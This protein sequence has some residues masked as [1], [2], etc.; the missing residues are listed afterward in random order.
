M[1]TTT[2]LA[3][4]LVGLLLD[5]DPVQ[6]TL[7]G[8][9]GRDDRLPVIGAAAEWELRRRCDDIRMR[10]MGIDTAHAGLE[11]RLTV[12]VVVQHAQAMVDH[13]DARAAEYT[14]IG[15][16]FAPVAGLLFHLGQIRIAD[17]EQGRDY[18]RRLRAIPEFTASAADRHRAGVAAG[19]LPVRRL[20]DDA[21]AHLDAHLAAPDDDPLLVPELPDAESDER[22]RVLAELVRPALRTYRRV[23]ADEIAPHGRED[24]RPG[25]CWLPG[26]PEI[27]RRLI[28]AHTTT[29]REPD[30]LHDTGLAHLRQVRAEL[31]A[32][33]ERAF[34]TGDPD[35]VLERLRTDPALRWRDAAEM[36]G[37][38]RTAIGRAEAAA[39]GWFGRLPDQ[40]CEVREVPGPASPSTPLGFYLSPA[41]DGSRP[42]VYFANTA[43]ADQR[44]RYNAEV[45]AFHEVIPGHHLQLGLAQELG[46]L[47][48]LRRLISINSYTEGWGLYTERLADEMGLY[49]DD[50]A[51]LGMISQ[52]AL[53]AARLV[54]DTGLHEAGWSRERAVEFLL[55][56]TTLPRLEAEAEVDRYISYPAQALSYLVGRL[57]LE[58]VRDAAR[59]RQGERFEL[60]RFHDV[61]LGHGALPVSAL[62]TLC[63]EELR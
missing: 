2:E 5:A 33:G 47:P 43:D 7:Y 19:R 61:I 32:V 26:G 41:L 6:A 54:V 42:G 63:A 38:A 60:R 20:V 8:I 35:E 11:E 62:D 44:P 13:F 52:D 24:R 15:N 18:L 14:I 12:A 27:Y 39:P 58:R 28:R 31:G 45:I 10:A 57:E 55:A 49:S 40:P 21:I 3:D 4:E 22:R 17:A 48:L 29:E 16:L 34:G 1:T 9:R 30:E 46:G 25:L 56:H 37:T 36:L 23:L 50:V 59:E 53:R 51:R